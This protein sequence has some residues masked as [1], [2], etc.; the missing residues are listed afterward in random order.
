MAY[1]KFAQFEWSIQRFR[2]FMEGESDRGMVLTAAC[3]LHDRLSQLYEEYQDS[4]VLDPFVPS[5]GST[6]GRQGS[7]RRLVVEIGERKILPADVQANLDVIREI[8][9]VFAHNFSAKSFRIVS[10]LC[11][12][13]RGLEQ[14]NSDIAEPSIEIA[15]EQFLAA[16]DI[17]ICSVYGR[18]IERAEQRLRSSWRESQE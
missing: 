9:N 18:L 3:F 11:G 6:R 16:A 1:L 14:A 10:R 5:P 8:R 12:N 4:P 7:F 15:R 17:A 13:L 2:Q